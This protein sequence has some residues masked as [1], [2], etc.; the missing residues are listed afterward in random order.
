MRHPILYIED[1]KDLKICPLDGSKLVER[2]GLD[3]PET[4]KVRLKE[5]KDRTFPVIELFEKEGIEV[6]KIKGEQSVADVFSDILK[7]LE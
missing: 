5:Y 7:S 3:D 4:I 2:K 1:T 6:K